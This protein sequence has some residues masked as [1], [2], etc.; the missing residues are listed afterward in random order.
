MARA[1]AKA[2][3]VRTKRRAPAR[4][5]HVKVKPGQDVHIHVVGGRGKEIGHAVGQSD[6]LGNVVLRAPAVPPGVEPPPAV[7]SAAGTLTPV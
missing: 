3:T 6:T 4:P 7:E 5:K 1:R 2:K